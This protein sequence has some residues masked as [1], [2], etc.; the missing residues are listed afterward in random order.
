MPV[1][2]KPVT[3]KPAVKKSATPSTPPAPTVSKAEAVRTALKH[4]VEAPADISAFAKDKYGLDI[5]AQQAGTYK[6]QI[7]AKQPQASGET[8]KAIP[9]AAKHGGGGETDLIIATEM[10]KPLVKQHGADRL[11][12][13]VDLLD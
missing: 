9:A 7:R 5:P 11:K 13:I 6:A 10:L 3:K 8:K 12:K 1:P 4:G 2:S